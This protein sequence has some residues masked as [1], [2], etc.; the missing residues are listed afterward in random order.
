MSFQCVILRLR[1]IDDLALTEMQISRACFSLDAN[2][3]W[4]IKASETRRE[5]LDNNNYRK[6]DSR[7]VVDPF[8]TIRLLT[9]PI[10]AHFTGMYVIHMDHRFCCYSHIII[11]KHQRVKKSHR[12]V[13]IWHSEN[14]QISCRTRFKDS[15][16]NLHSDHSPVSARKTTTLLRVTGPADD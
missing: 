2:G 12:C 5:I 10:N 7:W 1:H 6:L 14:F 15:F 9:E 11:L 16:D 13:S 4:E 3:W 8:R